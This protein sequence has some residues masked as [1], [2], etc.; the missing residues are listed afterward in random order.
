MKPG[1][2]S[3]FMGPPGTGKRLAALLIGKTAGCDVYRID[4]PCASPPKTQNETDKAL[5]ALF[6]QAQAGNWILLGQ[7]A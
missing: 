7:T 1:Y 5:D 4:L 6:A 2:R 3:L